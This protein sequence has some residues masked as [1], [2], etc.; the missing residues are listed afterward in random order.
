MT[1]WEH[2][3]TETWMDGTPAVWLSVE[4]YVTPLSNKRAALTR[5]T[6]ILAFQD[7]LASSLPTASRWVTRQKERTGVSRPLSGPVIE[8]EVI[9]H[10]HLTQ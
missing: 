2:G 3:W 9:S 6:Q 8:S 4:T 10:G 1:V 5:V 7:V